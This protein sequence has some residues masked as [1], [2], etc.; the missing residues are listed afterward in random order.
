MQPIIL[1]FMNNSIVKKCNSHFSKSIFLTVSHTTQVNCRKGFLFIVFLFSVSFVN[2]ATITSTATGGAWTT[3]STWVGGV[4][5]LS[6]DT[7][8]IATTGANSVTAILTGRTYTCAVLTINNG[9]SLLIRR[10][11]TVNGATSISGT[12]TFGST[13]TR[14]RTM[15]FNGAVTLN[16]TALWI[17]TT[18]SAAPK[19]TFGNNFVNNA[20]TFT[21]LTGVHT[22]KG[23]A[24]TISGATIS[25][26]PNISITGSYT[27]NGSVT[28]STSIIGTG[29]LTNGATGLLTIG[30]TITVTTLTAT[31]VANTVNYNGV[32]QTAKVTTYHNLILSGSNA[33]TFATT[34]TVN[35]VLSLESTASIFVTTG[36][37]T[38]GANATLQYNKPAAYVA[39]SEEWITPFNGLGGIIIANTGAIS[40]NTAKVLNS[41]CPV[42]INAGAILT[43]A[44]NQ[45]TF[46]GNF[47]NSGT[48]NAGSSIIDI[49]GTMATQ[50][51]SGFTTTGLVSMTKTSGTATFTSNVSGAAFTI[52]GSGGTLNLGSALT[53][54]FSGIT[55]LTA[56]TLNGGSSILN[57][58]AVSTTAWNGNGALFVAGTST[59]NFNASGNQ[60]LSATAT[61]FNNLTFSNSGI[62]SIT[63][64][65]CIANGI[66]S[67][68]GLA[69]V[70][71]APT[72]GTNAK[73]RYNTTT[74]RTAGVE[75]I[76]PFAATGGVE[77]ANSGAI[78]MNV[79]KVFNAS[80]PLTISSGATLNTANLQLNLGGNF[81]NTSGTFNAGSSP[82][83]I[84]NTM[85]S[86][87]IAGFTTTGLVSMTKATGTAT[88][89][90]NVNASGLTL[91][92]SS[93]TLNLGV[94]L[95]HTFTTNITRT[96]GT[97]NGGSSILKFAGL[98]SGTGGTF[99]ANTGTIEYNGAAQNVVLLPYYNLV[100]S[101]SG[102]KTFA[103]ST[104][105]SNSLSI[106]SG[107]VANLGTG[108]LHTSSGLSLGGA[109][110]VIG[111]WGGTGSG[112][113]NINTTY[114]SASTGKINNNCSV[115]VIV[116][117][118]NAPSPICSGNGTQTIT[119]TA[120]GSGLQYSWRKNGVALI[121]G[122]VV[123]GQGTNALVL[124]NPV[125]SDAGNYD[126]IV[127]GTCISSVT[128]NTVVV[129]INALPNI[130]TQP[131][132]IT[133]CQNTNASFSVTTSAV[134]PTYQWQYS[135]NPV[136]TWTN[137][138]SLVG[139]SGHTNSNL[140]LANVP[141]TY[142]NYNFRCV[143]TSNSGCITNSNPALLTINGISQVGAISANQYICSG[144]TLQSNIAI[145]SA[146]GVVQWQKADN[147]A[148]TI[149][150]SSIGT[151]ATVLTIAEVGTLSSTTYFRAVVTNG[152]CSSAISNTVIAIVATTTW[153]SAGGGSWTNGAP[154]GATAAIISYNYTST[155][156]LE[157]CNLTVNNGANVII[158]S[159]DNVNLYGAI[160]VSSGSFTLNNNANLTQVTDVTNTG[161]I[162]VKRASAA[163]MRLDYTLW[164]SPVNGQQMQSFSP[165]TLSNRF[166]TY[167]PST[168]LYDVI[169]S[170]STTNFETGKS[171]LIRTPNN[172]PTTPTIW[173]GTFTGLPNNGPVS[174]SV[175]NATFNAVG[176]PYPSTIEA[177]AFIADNNLTDPIY[178]WRK[179]N[180]A[181]NTSYATYT[182]AGGVSNSGDQ[183]SL[184]PNGTIQV[185]QGFVVKSTSTSLN[186]TNA[187]RISDNVNQFL[188][189]E[190]DRSRVWLNLTNSAGFFSQTLIAYMDDATVGLDPAIDGRFFN[191]SQTALTSIINNE[192]FAIQ[193]R[194][195]PFDSNDVVALGFKSALP[196]NYTI[197]INS[198]DG[199]FVENE[200][201]FLR[202]NLTNTMHD[203]RTSNYTFTTEA[204]VFNTRFEIL[205]LNPLGVHQ[206][207]FNENAVVVYKQNQDIIV[208]SNA[209][210]MSNVKVYDSR[211][212]LLIEKKNINASEIKINPGVSNQVLILKI[213]SDENEV[214][215][216]KVVN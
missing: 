84:E 115:P 72:Y 173:T 162:I 139:V 198:V 41:S 107:V 137:T 54:N 183:L 212:R 148:F 14:V 170:P 100:L 152:I 123:S 149:N 13:S 143:V 87:S 94:G 130:T 150:V 133:V 124:T 16:S 196:G 181:A 116:T 154:N 44:N 118:P 50:S 42:L 156:D 205:Y 49:N 206:N 191:D 201:I 20:A 204:G 113:T 193:G 31:A 39:T 131:T 166:Y 108:L 184:I 106:T 175:A 216:K 192:E 145:A 75:W 74:A 208:N 129:T 69:T 12:I 18:V 10:N 189:L 112:A 177:D 8:I 71:A 5:P 24:M 6:T 140:S 15:T 126:V 76:T 114:F 67:M 62:K 119:V 43:T 95:T 34:P 211:G 68:E 4:V 65:T 202:D 159:G 17:E 1:K 40:M 32:A 142:N 141:L 9:A 161:N 157:A 197:A 58:N 186:F 64:A 21:A 37:V 168:N 165:S 70:S 51:I 38:Y 27:N 172:H 111:S 199:L 88:F 147:A 122:G 59:V 11:F 22:F 48:F 158:S 103:A 86:Q 153:T 167:N 209:T 98:L 146:T 33:K 66:V 2:A 91:N 19:I 85:A 90:G 171:V 169:S 203:L 200:N 78:T 61:T 136:T 195:L 97:L 29:S 92:G 46:G 163:I 182:T 127:G 89:L 187:M 214:V 80:V 102:I 52:N 101:G 188:K 30:G 83:I 125:T 56:G 176:N 77:I 25:A 105:I 36:V 117:Q 121:N 151:N 138:N 81:I 3:G 144:T 104:T 128:S 185:G 57:E 28:S 180:N 63:T 164:S 120:S 53:H 79:A 135:T 7:V 93:G 45:L 47:T 134:S 155:G 73:L 132:S 60:T 210:T 178:F 55:T 179:T 207:V 35:G 82:I 23:T 213:T 109:F 190:E 194:S 99:I 96:A 110:Q 26:M 215:T 160:T 174:I